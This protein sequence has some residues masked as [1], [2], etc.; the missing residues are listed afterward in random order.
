MSIGSSGEHDFSI[1]QLV[2]GSICYP[3]VQVLYE[4]G[5]IWELPQQVSY[6]IYMLNQSGESEVSFVWDY[7]EGSNKGIYDGRRSR[8]ILNFDNH[9]QKNVDNDVCRRFRL[10]WRSLT[11]WD[12]K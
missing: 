3:F 8:Y 11:E 6:Q 2:A 9:I 5:M 10:V 7:G 12:Y 4:K 1:A